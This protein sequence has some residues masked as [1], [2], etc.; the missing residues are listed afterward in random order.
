MYIGALYQKSKCS[1]FGHIGA[2]FSHDYYAAVCRSGIDRKGQP[3]IGQ[4]RRKVS[5]SG[6][7]PRHA[8]YFDLLLLISSEEM[9]AVRGIA[10]TIP[11]LAEMPEIVSSDMKAVENIW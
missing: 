7:R 3:K 6:E 2:V 8:C 11:I 4:R 1:A 5:P 9:N 10:R